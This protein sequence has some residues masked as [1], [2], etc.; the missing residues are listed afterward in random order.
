MHRKDLNERSP[1]RVLERS[2]HGGLG[3]GNLGV[4]VARAGVGKTAFLVGIAMDD[5]LRGRK[6]VHVALDQPVDRVREYYHEIFDDLARTTRLDEPEA[7]RVAMRRNRNIHAYL[8]FTFSPAKLREDLILLRDQ[9]DFAP[10]AV[11][12]DGYDFDGASLEQVE[13][14]KAIAAEFDVE[15]WLAAVTHRDSRRDAR[16]IPEPVAH[17]ESAISVVLAMAHDGKAVHVELLKD[18]DNDD[19]SDL[20]LAL[21]PRTMLLV[22]E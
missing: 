1:L 15:M 3:R 20:K 19:V 12:V 14:L 21:D 17:V 9:M 2:I 8:D 10:V 11:I 7:E 4:V 16:G 18:H 6:V 13:E 22:E 5:L